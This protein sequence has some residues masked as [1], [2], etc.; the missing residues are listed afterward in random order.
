[1]VKITGFSFPYSD[2]E[3]RIGSNETGNTWITFS[4][5]FEINEF[6]SEIQEALEDRIVILDSTRSDEELNLDSVTGH[7]SVDAR[8]DDFTGRDIQISSLLEDAL[9]FTENSDDYS[10]EDIV[11]VYDFPTLPMRIDKVSG[12]KTA[13]Y[14]ESQFERV[15]S[16]DVNALYLDLTDDVEEH[17]STSVVHT[18]DYEPPSQ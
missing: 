17:Y 6:Y 9:S 15:L 13:H 8:P 11:L 10:N 18:F 2:L 3:S 14:I 7:T 5:P 12:P 4:D 1:V 16:N